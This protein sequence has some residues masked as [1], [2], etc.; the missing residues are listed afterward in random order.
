M[1]LMFL[2]LCV[3]GLMAQAP[4]KFTYQAVVRNASNALVANA[5]V[6][7]RVSVLSGSAAGSPVYVETHSV[8]TNANGLITLEIGGGTVQTGSFLG[9]SWNNGVYFLKTEIDPDGGSNYSVT[10]TQ[11][12]LSVPYA[13]YAKEAANGFSGDYNDLTNTPTIPT[14]PTSVSAFSNDAGYITMDSIPA[15]PTVPTNVSAFTNDAGYLTGYTETDPVFTAWDK[16]YNDLT[17]KPTI[18]TVP[19]NVSAFT[20]DAG[21]IT[22]DSIP[23]VP[24]VPTNV[25]AFTNDAGY[26]TMDSIPAIP[27]VPTNVSAF[28]NDAG[29]LTGYT[30]TD[31]VFTAWDKSYNDLTDK[32]VIPTVPTNVSAFTNDAGYITMDSIPAIPTVPTNVSAFTND[33]GYLTGYTET[34]PVFT[35]WDKNYNDLTNKPTIPTVPTNVSAFTNDAGYLTS[36]TE[37]QVLSISNDTLFLTGGSFVK[38]PAGFDGNYNSLT[39][40]PNL[41]TV[42]TSGSYNDL[43]DKPEISTVPTNVS[44][45]TNDAGYLTGYTETDPV[46]TAWNKSYNDLTD[47]PEI[48]TVPSNVS[49]FTND[50]GYIT[51][52]SV[53]AIPTNV[54]AFT[55]DAGYLTAANV[56]EAANIPTNVSAFTNDAGYLTTYTETDPVFTAWNKDY[57]DLTNTPTIP[58]VPTNV[59]AFTNDAGYITMDSIP[60]IPTVPTDVSAF[61]NDAGYM[62]S[63]T[64]TDPLYSAWNKSYNDL[65]DKPVIPAA[66]NDATLT[67]QKNGSTVGTFSADATDN[68][69]VNITVPTQTSQLEN[70]SGYLTMADVQQLLDALNQRIDSLE[71]VINGGTTPIVPEDTVDGGPC[72]GHH[73]LTDADGN[74][75]N[76]VWIGGQ[77]WMK[78]NLRTS[79]YA[80]NTQIPLGNQSSASD[81]YR[82]NPNNDASNVATYGYLYNWAAVMHGSA[83]ST[84]NPSNVQGVCP[85]GWHVPSNAEWSQ[86]FNY[87]RDSNHN[88]FQCG[89][90]ANNVAKAVAATTGWISVATVCAV[91][92]TPED[93]NQSGFS[94][95]PA[96]FYSGSYNAPGSYARFWTATQSSNTNAN[97]WYLHYASKLLTSVSNY[98]KYYGM[99]V[100]CVLGEGEFA[101][102][103][104]V[105]TATVSEITDTTAT[106]GGNVTADGGGNVMARGV[107]WSTSQ[108]PTINDSHTTDGNGTGSFTSSLTGLAAGTTYYVRAYATN[109]AGTVYGEEVS[110]TTEDATPTATD[111]DPCPGTPTL[112]DVDGNTYNTVKIGEQCWMKENLRTT[113]YADNDPIP[114]GTTTSYTEAFRY[115]PYGDPANVATY[116]YLYNWTAVMHGAGSSSS[117]PSHVQG[118]C[119][120]GWHMPS[121]SEWLQLLNYLRSKSELTCGGSVDRVA[122]ALASTTGWSTSSLSCTVGNTPENNN[123]SGFNALPAGAY[124]GT[125]G[126]G[127]AGSDANFWTTTERSETTSLRQ[128]LNYN[129]SMFSGAYYGRYYAFSVRCVQGAADAIEVAPSV[130]TALTLS[131]VTQT[132]ITCGGTVTNDGGSAV[133]ARGVCWSTGYNPSLTEGQYTVDGTGTGEFVSHLTGL[134]PG[135]TYRVWAYAT[136]AVGT[137]FGY[138]ATFTTTYGTD[139]QPCAGAATVTDVDGNVYNTVMVGNVCWMKEN[140]RTTKFP[141]GTPIALGTD[142]SSTVPYRYYPDNNPD[143]VATYGYLYN[144]SAFIHNQEGQSGNVQGICPAGWHIPKNE[145]QQL[146]NYVKGQ[147][148]YI[149]NGNGD[150]NAQALASPEG[151]VSYGTSCTPGNA[152][153]SNNATGFS[154]LPAGYYVAN[155]VVLYVGKNTYLWQ[156][157][158]NGTVNRW[159]YGM[160]YQSPIFQGGG[161]APENVTKAKGFSVRCVHN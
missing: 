28:T 41:S 76:T 65:T 156:A 98:E 154:L 138:Q 49:A 122:K 127:T 7:V 108:N 120:A 15:I 129:N 36:F 99:S 145:M 21:Y 12:L 56:Q 159:P 106:C 53:P 111:G 91:G 131:E 104:T 71:N 40:K 155:N 148:D 79:K 3:C 158:S 80:D 153:T 60:A 121:E 144:W 68:K 8:N 29:Y 9:I 160:N 57:N 89:G 83:S 101:S 139:G 116:G 47:K 61:T 157:N 125:S 74:I 152:P 84:S 70:N 31:P 134:T 107:C 90:E 30:E 66:A 38:L 136:N 64:E 114:L 128:N 115:N 69:T 52:D 132:T 11:Q 34:D 18:P 24:T 109:G 39:N 126:Y 113:K 97:H 44:A 112:T 10:T 20:N 100:R 62:T 102:L 119:P 26:I 142:S 82:Y 96:G 94:A 133:T 42:A 135:T 37:Q 73:T 146:A 6:G 2:V 22:M 87:L 118:I 95:L 54:S 88:Q 85:A 51:M 78:E 58:T 48:P 72:P 123:L 161:G 43:T 137:S 77:C 55:N 27:T 92:N 14:V 5:P 35:A 1:L 86:L 4:E 50:A 147:S 59:S 124:Y 46:F 67:I 63:Y 105:T 32:P 33:A 103:P 93:N 13:L 140:L 16:N 25:S 19:T 143:Y 45:F 151:W 110:F 141:D 23:A 149:C 75:Y 117:N 150:Y 17:N 81:A 130:T